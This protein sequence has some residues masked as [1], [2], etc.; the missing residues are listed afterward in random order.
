LVTYYT[1]FVLELAS[2][3][4]GEFDAT[5]RY[6]LHGASGPHAHRGRRR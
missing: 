1:L 4:F 2:R 6:R 5:S 3:P